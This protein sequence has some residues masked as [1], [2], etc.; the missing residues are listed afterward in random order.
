MQVLNGVTQDISVLLHFHW[1]EHVYYCL[2]ETSFPSESQE[3]SGHFVGF[4]DH[5]GHALTFVI[6]TNDTQKIIYWSEVQSAED[7]SSINL[8]TDDWGDDASDHPDGN[9]DQSEDREII[10]SRGDK[11]EK[12]PM[13]IIDVE[14]LIGKTFNLLSDDSQPSTATIIEAINSHE[15]DTKWHSNSYSVPD[16]TQQ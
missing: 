13:A 16:S 5:V 7:P 8:C 15:D 3:A 12:P 1:Y 10:C 2:D 14:D 6:F 9:T 4:A 11:M